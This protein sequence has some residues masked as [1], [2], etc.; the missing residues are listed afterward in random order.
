M[1]INKMKPLLLNLSNYEFV[2]VEMEVLNN[3][4]VDL[5]AAHD[6]YVD[7]SENESDIEIANSWYEQHDGDVFKFKLCVCVII[8][9][10]RKDS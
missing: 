2:S 9:P 10:K 6:N 7:S 8:F 3:L 1:Q 4:L 5:Q